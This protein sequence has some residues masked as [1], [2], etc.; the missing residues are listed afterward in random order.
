MKQPRFAVSGAERRQSRHECSAAR[1]SH[2]WFGGGCRVFTIH[3]LADSRRLFRVVPTA[4][5]STWRLARCNTRRHLLTESRVRSRQ[6]RSLS[7]APENTRGGP[8]FALP[9]CRPACG[10]QVAPCLKPGTPDGCEGL[11]AAEVAAIYWVEAGDAA[12]TRGSRPPAPASGL[13]A[14]LSERQTC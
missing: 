13:S 6:V 14:I 5:T 3:R 12:W 2:H 4:D 1:V 11:F 9:R 8:V 7:H 10:A